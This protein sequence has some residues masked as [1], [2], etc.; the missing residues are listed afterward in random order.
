M[1]NGRICKVSCEWGELTSKLTAVLE[2]DLHCEVIKDGK[3]R[4]MELLKERF[5]YYPYHRSPR[6]GGI[7]D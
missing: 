4:V 2:V 5:P 3:R 1:Q 7:D 6:F